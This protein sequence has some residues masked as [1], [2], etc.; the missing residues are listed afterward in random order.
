L[1]EIKYSFECYRR[2]KVLLVAESKWKTLQKAKTQC[3]HIYTSVSQY[4]LKSEL[5][6]MIESTKVDAK[7]RSCEVPGTSTGLSRR[8]DELRASEFNP[9]SGAFAE[10]SGDHDHFTFGFIDDSGIDTTQTQMEDESASEWNCGGDAVDVDDGAVNSFVQSASQIRRMRKKF[11]LLFDSAVPIVTV[12]VGD[13]FATAS[14][15]ASAPSSR[16]SRRSSPLCS[17]ERRGTATP[18]ASPLESPASATSPTSPHLH[19]DAKDNYT[20]ARLEGRVVRRVTDL[21]DATNTGCVVHC[22]LLLFY[23]FVYSILLFAL[24]VYHLSSQGRFRDGAARGG[25]HLPRGGALPRWRHL[26]RPSL[27][28][29]GIRGRVLGV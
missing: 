8:M 17:P 11:E 29:R 16:S 24:Y 20:N 26:R 6:D 7:R 10:S 25:H 19:G 3:M 2:A 12:F 27:P 18:L 14:N 1:G 21:V 15:V 23:S 9:T 5:V 4:L 28:T 22:P 13:S